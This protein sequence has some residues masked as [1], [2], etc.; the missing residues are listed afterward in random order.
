MRR[1]APT[2]IRMGNAEADR[3]LTLGLHNECLG[4]EVCSNLPAPPAQGK[5]CTENGTLRGS[6][7]V[8]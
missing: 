5:R 8:P 2:R 6:A 4:N 3:S 7:L 1:C